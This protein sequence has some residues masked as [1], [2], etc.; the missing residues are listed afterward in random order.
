MP[1]KTEFINFLKQLLEIQDDT[2][3][4]IHEIDEYFTNDKNIKEKAEMILKNKKNH[5][6]IIV[7]IMG[8][9]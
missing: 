4:A 9:I 3:K 6:K 1:K 7:E 2:E 8:I 5:K